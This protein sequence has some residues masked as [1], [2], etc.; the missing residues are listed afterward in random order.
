[1]TL[2]K[3]PFKNS[4]RKGDNAGNKH[5]PTTFSAHPKKNIHSKVVFVLSSANTLSFDQSKNLSIGKELNGYRTIGLS[6]YQ[7]TN[8]RLFQT[9]RV[10]R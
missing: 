9:G 5:F 1:M 6:H 8:F 2:K 3:K 7:M 4:M 10:C